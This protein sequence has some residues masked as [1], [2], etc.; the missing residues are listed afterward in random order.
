MSLPLFRQLMRLQ[1]PNPML[2]TKIRNSI[3]ALLLIA[4]TQST[5]AQNVLIK[6]T[7]R[8]LNKTSQSTLGAQNVVVRP[9]FDPSKSVMTSTQPAGYFELKTDMPFSKLVDKQVS[10]YLVSKC[11]DCKPIVQRVFV[12]KPLI[13]IANWKLDTSCSYVEMS[14]AN[15]DKMLAESKGVKGTDLA[16][17]SVGSAA[18]AAPSLLNTITNSFFSIISI[19]NGGDFPAERL[20][21]KLITYGQSEFGSYMQNTAT[22][23]FNF[24]QGRDGSEAVFSNVATLAA[25]SSENNVSLFTNFRNNLKAGGYFK[26]ANKLSLGAGVRWYGQ[27]EF[28]FV[29]YERED[30]NNIEHDSVSFKLNEYIVNLAG[31]YKINEKLAVGLSIK[32]SIQNFSRPIQATVNPVPNPVVFTNQ[33]DSKK[34]IDADL[35]VSYAATESLNLGATVFNVLG[36]EMYADIFTPAQTSREYFNQRA[37]GLGAT[38]KLN[39]F[40]FGVD[41]L[42]NKE[43]LYDISVGANYVPFNNALISAGFAFLNTSYSIAFRMKYFRIAYV[44]DNDFLVNQNKEGKSG[45][46]N[47]RLHSGFVFDF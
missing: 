44:N 2:H 40:N 26:V 4:A 20:G 17:A 28:R 16:K 11:N 1:L 10:V 29:H 45:L 21:P 46:F 33:N 34:N 14:A 7:I 39:R 27:D 42:M 18:L 15:A 12:S 38:Y 37:L 8:C 19:T 47:G 43:G 6:G 23:G 3:S 5:Q 24:S 35:S 13:T 32:R 36:T 31:S 41:A 30:G 22:T 25:R 9:D